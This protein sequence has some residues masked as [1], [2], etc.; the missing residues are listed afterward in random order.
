MSL[1]YNIIDKNDASNRQGLLPSYQYKKKRIIWLNTFYATSRVPA[2]GTTYRELTFDVPQFQLFNQTK[3]SVISYVSNEDAVKPLIIKLMN[4]MHDNQST[5]SNDRESYPIIYVNNQK[6]PGMLMND[7]ISVI[8]LPQVINNIV[9]KL[10]S[11]FVARDAGFTIS[12][13]NAGHFILGLLFEDNDL[14]LD[15]IVSQ[16]K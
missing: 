7:K 10:N 12:A 15:N 2:S 1:P 11:S 6:I 5:Y 16:Y 14:E 4:L 8:L 9:I 3:L 13:A